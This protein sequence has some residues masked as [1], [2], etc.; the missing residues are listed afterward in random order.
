MDAEY[1]VHYGHPT[2]G[3][4]DVHEVRNMESL[5]QSF[6]LFNS[7]ACTPKVFKDYQI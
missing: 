1:I 2:L 7:N 3:G 4:L 6:A 5:Y